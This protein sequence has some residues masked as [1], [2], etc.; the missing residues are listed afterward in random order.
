MSHTIRYL[1]ALSIITNSCSLVH[2]QKKITELD[3]QKFLSSEVVAFTNGVILSRKH[4]TYSLYDINDKTSIGKLQPIQEVAISHACKL[5]DEA[6]V[7]Q[8]RSSADCSIKLILLRVLGTADI[9]VLK[10]DFEKKE[11]SMLF[12]PKSIREKS[13]YYLEKIHGISSDGLAL[14]VERYVPTNRSK[15]LFEA[16]NWDGERKAKSTSLKKFSDLMSLNSFD[17]NDLKVLE[18]KK[19]TAGKG[20]KYNVCNEDGLY[21]EAVESNEK[22]MKIKLEFKRHSGN[23]SVKVG[24]YVLNASSNLPCPAKSQGK[25]CYA[26]SAYPSSDLTHA[27]VKIWVDRN[28]FRYEIYEL[29]EADIKK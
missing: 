6:K 17:I 18:P 15:K 22:S 1:L 4:T 20:Q 28:K 13:I 11:M 26:L 10:V 8:I 14:V 19:G 5:C 2:A 21:A 7:F 24:E 9:T 12:I 3:P 25:P 27:M 16:I 23:N 29:P